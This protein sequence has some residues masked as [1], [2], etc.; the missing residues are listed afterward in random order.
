MR[1]Q[2]DLAAHCRVRVK[3]AC[4]GAA[5]FRSVARGRT[6]PS[7]STER[8][9]ERDGLAQALPPIPEQAVSST[10]ADLNEIRERAHR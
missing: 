6:Q 9:C 3:A 10:E 7:L 1:P 8:E 2:A 4:P 5:R